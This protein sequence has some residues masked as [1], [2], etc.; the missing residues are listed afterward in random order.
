M[1]KCITFDND[2]QLKILSGVKKVSQAVGST[3]GPAGR[4][5]LIE[6]SFGAPLF[7]KDG[8]T[9]AKSIDLEDKVE[10]LGAQ[11][12]KEIATK[13]DD[14]CGDGTTTSTVLAYSLLSEGLKA[15]SS[16]VN[17][18]SLKSGIDKAVSQ[19]EKALENMSVPVHT[20]DQIVQVASI[21]ANN[22][23]EIGNLIADAIESVG[24]DGVITTADS[25]SIDTN[26]EYVEGMQF[27]RG[28]IS[29]YFAAKYEN[30][31]VEME[32]PLILLYD[33][34]ISSTNSI[35]SIL[36]KVSKMQKP[37]LIISDNIEGE[38]LT[39]L[40]VNHLRG[41]INVCAVKAPGFGDR[42]KAM[43][44]DIAILTG[45][46][47]IDEDLG[48]K[49]E[50]TEISDLGLCASVKITRDK[51]IIVDGSGEDS[52]IQARASALRR[53]MEEATSE[54]DREKIQ[55]RLAKIVGGVAVINVGALDES[56]LKEKKFRIEDAINATRAAVE[57]GV[58]PGG[59]VAL[60]QTGAKIKKP[61]MT[62][63]ESIG[64]NIVINSLSKPIKQIAE[65]SGVDGSVVASKCAS[66]KQN[67]GYDALNKK[68][69]NML[70]AGIID[71]TKV[72][73]NALKNAASIASLI[74]TSSCAVTEIPKDTPEPMP[75][76]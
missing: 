74:I 2:M 24:N 5:V 1:S 44:E 32:E 16:G 69:V 34:T 48:M 51:T 71:P 64:Y 33:K 56:T 27:D 3:L 45:G 14:V 72:T 26:I 23:K 68:W 10:N 15:I 7:T 47:L 76:V 39:T 75:E 8:I 57:S 54:Y 25:K 19:V 49:L 58:L 46:K 28:Y 37:L 18:I 30:Q 9:V 52:E 70:D 36:E 55:E 31:V 21:S 17:P 67:T 35:L 4:T 50:T 60:C 59:G 53:E 38:A 62:Q 61:K 6:Q 12:I 42:K 20:K 73:I 29:P 66:S 11:M 43:L 41:I 65:N 40:V 22:D 63:D 13:T